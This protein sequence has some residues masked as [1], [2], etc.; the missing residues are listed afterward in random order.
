MKDAL[1]TAVHAHALGAVTVTVAVPPRSPNVIDVRDVA[2]EHANA[3]WLTVTVR[4]AMV[5]VPVRA[6]P[7]LASTENV[8]VPSSLPAL[9]AVTVMNASL[10][11]DVHAP[12][13][14]WVETFTV[15]VP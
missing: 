14:R 12:S 9:P 11:H 5:T 6:N 2:Y 13:S 7:V 8:T 1:L 4:P 10:R 15:R 3:A